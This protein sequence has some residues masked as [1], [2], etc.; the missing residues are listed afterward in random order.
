MLRKS[1]PEHYSADLTSTPTL[2]T[3]IEIPI[4]V[5]RND[6]TPSQRI[7]MGREVSTVPKVQNM[8]L[9]RTRKTLLHEVESRS[10]EITE[11]AS[12]LIK[13]PSENP[14]GN[15]D[16]ITEFL[17]KYLR[18]TG[19][20][21]SVVEGF[22]GKPSLVCQTGSEQDS[23]I[24][25]LNGHTDV[26]PVGSRERWK[27]DPF[28]GEIKDGYIHGRG[29][30]DMKAGLAGI[31]FAFTLLHRERRELKGLLKLQLV[32]DEETGGLHGTKW[33]MNGGYADST[34][35]IIAEPTGLEA[36]DIGQKGILWLKIETKGT[37]AHGS[38]A[39]YVGDNAILKA[40]SLTKELQS[41]TRI[42]ARPPKEI[43]Q[44]ISSSISI[45]EQ[46]I[47]KKG[48]GRILRTPT[49][50]VGL[51]SG[52]T[53]VN[54]VPDMCSTDVDIRLPIGVKAQEVLRK[55]RTI[56]TKH[57]AS[58]VVISESPPNYTS[59]TE[60]IVKIL[61]RNVQEVTER[62][63][64]VFVQWATSDARFLRAKGIATAQYGPAHLEGI[65][66]FNEKVRADDVVA[67]TKVYV[68][69][70]LDYLS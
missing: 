2:V 60:E 45:A 55:V 17:V 58:V 9:T 57:D 14:P 43:R 18:D 69:L 63:P 25:L 68:A 8:S 29:A 40:A 7:N 35:A 37:L 36:I 48:I 28:G 56:A 65:H 33:L 22:K 21:V 19:V 52:G 15:V 27:F 64:R 1:R 49:V 30:S 54:M 16:K 26:V 66:G 3:K 32:P 12:D 10:S 51:I 6:E 5:F 39:P 47:G 24:L 61:E 42:R 44:V 38:L 34:A 62:K 67:A 20:D 23:R 11:L 53:K 50:N 70:A 59:P 41:I 46:L 13:I 31:V 4:D